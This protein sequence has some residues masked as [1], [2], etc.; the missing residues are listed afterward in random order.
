M[1][2]SADET[3]DGVGSMSNAHGIAFSNRVVEFVRNGNAN[4][5]R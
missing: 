4:A 5:Q 2:R 3:D 1:A